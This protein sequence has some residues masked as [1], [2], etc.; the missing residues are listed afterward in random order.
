MKTADVQ[1]IA[2][3]RMSSGYWPSPCAGR[4]PRPAGRGSRS[5]A[6]E[7]YGE[8]R[9]AQVYPKPHRDSA[10]PAG[11]RHPERLARAIEA[12]T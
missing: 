1:T 4:W 3:E 11:R 10:A 5:K 6:V 9:A 12:A 7:E 8:L 2:V